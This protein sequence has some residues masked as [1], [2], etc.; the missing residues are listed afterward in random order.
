MAYA[1]VSVICPGF[2]FIFGWLNRGDIRAK[3]DIE[4]NGCTDC[5]THYC[6][7][8]CVCLKYERC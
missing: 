8:C 2:A 4:G 6:C 5:L 1:A 7:D 3:Y